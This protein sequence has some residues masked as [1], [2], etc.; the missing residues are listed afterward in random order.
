MATAG[1]EYAVAAVRPLDIR[2]FMATEWVDLP[3]LAEAHGV[4]VT[5][6][7]NRCRW[8]MV[9]DGPV[10]GR[11][12]FDP[13]SAWD[14]LGRSVLLQS[15][16]VSW[17]P[18]DDSPTASRLDAALDAP[19]HVNAGGGLVLRHPQALDDSC[20]NLAVDLMVAE[21]ASV[22]M[23][24]VWGSLRHP[25]ALSEGQSIAA[26]LVLDGLVSVRG[27]AGPSAAL[28]AGEQLVTTAVPE[29]IGTVGS[30][31]LVVAIRQQSA[32]DV[33]WFGLQ[34][35]AFWP[36]ARMDVSSRPLE[37]HRA[38][39]FDDPTTTVDILAPIADEAFG[40]DLVALARRWWCA[41]LCPPAESRLG[42]GSPLDGAVLRGQFPGGVQPLAEDDGIVTVAAASTLLRMPSELT[43]L[44]SAFVGG[45]RVAVDRDL[46]DGQL[47]RDLIAALV[48]AGLVV[49]DRPDG[50]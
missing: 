39:G 16:L 48:D 26:V 22:E 27:D 46:E 35:A 28:E 9:D 34:R 25:E 31:T 47:H 37:P 2:T 13:T 29:L 15:P 17:V 18:P 8:M 23:W 10:P 24:L 14:L 44:L 1:D 45:K 40:D 30:L 41:N 49:I 20:R 19:G 12:R 7:R 36:R 50:S 21:T 42:P 6:A 4:A 32:A 38:Y 5:S 43:P 33:H 11:H 3:D